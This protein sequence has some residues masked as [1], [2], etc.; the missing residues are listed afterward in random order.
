MEVILLERVPN[1]GQMGQTVRVKDGYGRNFLL[2]RG[3]ALRATAANTAKFAAM[4]AQLEARNLAQKQEAEAVGAKLN[5][6]Q[7]IVIRTAGETGQ[8][9]GSVSSRD[10]ADL[11]TAGGVTV[12]RSQVVLEAPIKNIGL[13]NVSVHLHADVTV[14]VTVNVA[15]SQTE[16]ERQVK[17]EDMTARE[18][19]PTFETFK[20]EDFDNE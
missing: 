5:G 19:A 7:Y 2:P 15:R 11:I 13:H 18:A 12:A 4:K 1:L 3:K 10:L 16:A 8:L 9:Y 17:G 20:P 14:G 6:K